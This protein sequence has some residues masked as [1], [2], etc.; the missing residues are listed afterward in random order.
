[1]YKTNRHAAKARCRTPQGICIY[2]SIAVSIA[3]ALQSG[4][5]LVDT[6]G[7]GENNEM[8]QVLLDYIEKNN[9]YGFIYVIKSD[10]AGG[11]A[12]D[13]VSA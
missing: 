3:V 8:K 1:M 12:K 9:V 5:A 2:V 13:R 7:I 6:P 11:V 4:V 10:N